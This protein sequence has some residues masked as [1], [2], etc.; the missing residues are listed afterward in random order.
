MK[1]NYIVF[2]GLK[3]IST[4]IIILYK[5]GAINWTA[6]I[7]LSCLS[8]EMLLRISYNKKCKIYLDSRNYKKS[9]L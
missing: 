2:L 6:Y 3:F 7:I 1:L 9:V 4:L 8:V 5:P